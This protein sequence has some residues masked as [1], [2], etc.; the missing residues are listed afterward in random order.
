M[1]KKIKNFI[2]NIDKWDIIDYKG[3]SYVITDI[4]WEVIEIE[5]SDGW[6]VISDDELFDDMMESI[7]DEENNNELWR[8]LDK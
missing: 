8:I 2:D 5:N 6:K 3:I 4:D 7:S 1:N